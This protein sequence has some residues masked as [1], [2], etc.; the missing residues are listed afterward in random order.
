M[1]QLQMLYSSW[2]DKDLAGWI[3]VLL[4]PPSL[5]WL[6]G[7]GGNHSLLS[8]FNIAAIIFGP[9]K[10]NTSFNDYYNFNIIF[11][12]VLKVQLHCILLP[13]P[14]NGLAMTSCLLSQAFGHANAPQVSQSTGTSDVQP[15]DP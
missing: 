10:Y 5:V 7:F 2:L 3:E 11:C 15:P 9:D 1:T 12:F 4:L 8:M 6:L 14:F 13:L